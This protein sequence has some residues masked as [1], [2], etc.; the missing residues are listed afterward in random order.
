MEKGKALDVIKKLR[1]LEHFGRSNVV[2][3]DQANHSKDPLEEKQ[4]ANFWKTLTDSPS[5]P[6]NIQTEGEGGDDREAEV[7]VKKHK[8]LIEVELKHPERKKASA[9]RLRVL[10]VGKLFDKTTLEPHR[11]FIVDCFT[12]IYPW[13]GKTSSAVLRRRCLEK[14]KFMREQRIL[15]QKCYVAPITRELQGG[16]T[17]LFREQFYN[18]GGGIASSGIHAPSGSVATVSPSAHQP[19]DIKSLYDSAQNDDD[20][21]NDSNTD[22]MVDD[23]KSSLPLTIYR[24]HDAKKTRLPAKSKGEFYSSE[25]YIACYQYIF[26]NKDAAILYFWQGRTSSV[27]K[28]GTSAVLTIELDDSID[29][30]TKEI[31]VVQNK[32]PKHFLSVF[33]AEGMIVYLGKSDGAEG[34]TTSGGVAMFQVIGFEPPFVRCVQVQPDLHR[35]HSSSCFL[36]F[37]HDLMENKVKCFLWCGQSSSSAAQKHAKVM[38]AR[39]GKK[40]YGLNLDTD[41]EI[42]RVEEGCESLLVKSLSDLLQ[43]PSLWYPVCKQSDRV[44]GRLFDCSIGTGVFRVEQVHRFCQGDLLSGNVYFLD[45]QIYNSTSVSGKKPVAVFVWVGSRVDFSVTKRSLAAAV[46]YADYGYGTSARVVV[47]DE[48]FEPLSFTA[49]LPAWDYHSIRANKITV[50]M[51]KYDEEDEQYFRDGRV[52]LANFSREYTYEELVNDE[53]RKGLDVKNLEGY[54]SDSEFNGLLGMS[55]DDFAKLPNWKKQHLK[56]ELKLF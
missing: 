47:V 52:L 21:D 2:I 37:K 33:A 32:E 53:Q 43:T 49:M 15:H 36:L 51:P 40:L 41:Y 48:G 38:A 3:V 42:Q 12:E 30:L 35:F 1:N 39:I 31:R 46:E 8:R 50:N 13:T 44:T 14:A 10:C 17:V 26:N 29:G 27:L 25:S 11:C 6:G 56:K 24:V 28:K 23:G 22:V 54:L 20:N 7:F 45:T 55:K 34:G 16:E 4:A 5:P 19:V 9:V 18:W